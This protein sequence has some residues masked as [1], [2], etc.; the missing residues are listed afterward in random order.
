MNLN[1]KTNY[2]NGESLSA[3]AWN[4]LAS[5]V[6]ELGAAESTPGS[7]II[8]AEDVTEQGS[9]D[10]KM[11]ISITSGIADI[12]NTTVFELT[13]K[14]TKGVNVS[15]VG[16]NNINIEPRE[17]L[18]T[19]EGK[20]Q[21]NN[22]NRKGG[23]IAL[24]P[25]DDI[26]LWAHHRGSS[27]NDEVSVKV[28]TE[29]PNQSDPTKTD[30]VAAKLQLKATEITLSTKGKTGDN[31]NV[32]DV[33]VTGNDGKGYLKVK[34][35]AVDIRCSD[36]GIALQPKGEDI[37]HHENK[38][39]FESDGGDGLEFGTFNTQHTSIFTNDYRFNKDGIVYAAEREEPVE[40]HEDPSDPN[41]PVKK[42][43]YPTQ[44]D[45]FKDI[46]REDESCPWI[47]IVRL[48]R[49]CDDDFSPF[50]IKQSGNNI[51]VKS[52]Y[53][54]YLQLVEAPNDLSMV[55]GNMTYFP[56]YDASKTSYRLNYREADLLEF[57]TS[58]AGGRLD[59]TSVDERSAGT[60]I[61]YIVGGETKY[62]SVTRYDGGIDLQAEGNVNISSTNGTINFGENTITAG[63]SSDPVT[64]SIEDIIKLVNWF[65][66]SANAS[67][68]GTVNPFNVSSPL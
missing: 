59:I 34:A 50:A 31:A 25:G 30:E 51:L 5:D 67:D 23:N 66:D 54:W 3:E 61:Q 18:G 43:D 64:C 14:D 33:N 63:N 20:N 1:H 68:M 29:V 58:F 62:F 37:D 21:V 47:S 32:M 65:K 57:D 52:S 12:P 15:L 9:D 22:E 28:M 8:S 39:K 49:L 48:G 19:G 56:F 35:K 53:I 11:A 44:A 16:N 10:H 4:A 46:I 7:Q 45:D 6:N 2:Q 40:I 17:A 60:I 13:E 41:S 42:I 36:G 27:K 24:K 38:I 55:E 26:E